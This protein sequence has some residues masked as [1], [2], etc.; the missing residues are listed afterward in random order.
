MEAGKISEVT[1]E[2]DVIYYVEKGKD[3]KEQVYKTGRI[4]DLQEVD[5]LHK[6]DVVFSE[7]IPT[8]MNLL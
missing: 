4:S 5:R 1:L 6:A 3:N 2:S 8:K 7:E